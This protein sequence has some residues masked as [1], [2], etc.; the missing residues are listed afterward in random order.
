M[1]KS[2][3]KEN[4]IH[5]SSLFPLG[6]YKMV[7]QQG[8]K[9]LDCHWHE[10]W[11][12]LLVKEGC[13]VFQ[14][15][16]SYYELHA[17]QAIFIN[18]SNIHA[19]HPLNHLPCTYYALVFDPLFLCSH[20]F[21]ILQVN[22]IDPLVK[23]QLILPEFISGQEEWE[24]KIINRL[25][26]IFTICSEVPHGYEL[27][28][29]AE[30]LMILCEFIQNKNMQ[31]VEK[32]ISASYKSGQMKKIIHYI[33]TN[34]NKK[35]SIKNLSEVVGLS[36]GHFCRFFKQIMRQTPIEYINAY[37]VHIATRMIKETDRKILEVALSVGFDNLSYFYSV[38]KKHTHCTP[39]EYRKTKR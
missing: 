9:I 28:V 13:A 6:T 7:C 21:D 19:G 3:L 37:R 36:E 39:L 38:F 16:T 34:Y 24:K 12:F 4:R 11:E 18:G 5:G 25:L 22:F 30:L 32:N 31:K 14:I 27:A 26:T 1:D 35:I 15:E 8:D 33:H 20:G 29:K 10:E 23:R 17:G 2:I